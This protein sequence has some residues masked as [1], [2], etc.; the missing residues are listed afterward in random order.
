MLDV[1]S[2]KIKFLIIY[3]FISAFSIMAVYISFDYMKSSDISSVTN[4]YI[5]ASAKETASNFNK[6]LDIYFTLLD[7]ISQDSIFKDFISTKKHKMETE[8]H[9]LSTKKSNPYISEIKYVQNDGKEIIKIDEI[10]HPFENKI[11]S[12]IIGK[13]ELKTLDYK[14]EFN[15]LKKDE[16]GI[17]K[18]DLNLDNGKWTLL[19]EPTI[20]LGEL[21]YDN[22]GIEKGI[23]V[24]SIKFLSLFKDF[25]H[26][27]FYNIALVDSEGNFLIHDDPRYGLLSSNF[28]YS[29]K[30]EYPN[31]W[32][33]VLDED[34]YLGDSFYSYK[35]L[36]YG[37][38]EELNIILTNK[39]IDVTKQTKDFQKDFIVILVFLSL[40]LLPLVIYF[41]SLPDK[42]A[43]QMMRDFSKDSLTSLSNRFALMKDIQTDKFDGCLII[44]IS[45]D[46]LFKIQNTYGHT[47]SDK[48]VKQFV[49]SFSN[50]KGK[51]EFYSDS[52]NSY[53]LKYRYKGTDDLRTYV[54]KLMD[55]L[56]NRHFLLKEEN[57][58]FLL[59]ITIG[60]SNPANEY[61]NE[62]KLQEAEN[63]L[64]MAQDSHRKYDIYGVLHENNINFK[65][66]NISLAHNIKRY[67]DN[68]NVL[69][70]FQPI[71]NNM[72]ERI[73][74]YECL[75]RLKGDDGILFPDSFLPIAK[76]INQYYR[77]SYIMID[78]AFSFFQDKDYEFSI[79]LSVIDLYDLKFQEY[80]F[81]QIEKYGVAN[82]LVVEIVE[83]ESIN[84][85]DIF[86]DFAKRIKE[87]GAQIAIDDFGSGY[88]NFNY[89]IELSDYVDYLKIDGSLV[90]DIV[91]SHK[92]QILIGSLKFLSDNLNI[93]TIA[94]Y[95][96][97]E[98]VLRYLSSIGI[99]YSQ[100]YHIGKPLD[101][102]LDE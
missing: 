77:L 44:I 52:Y 54:N 41:A 17:S 31:E 29:L 71:Y 69:V 39:Y 27:E 46:N 73:E 26:T 72:T 57:I 43:K 70:Y 6:H 94:E 16:I 63:A 83:S 4:K 89:I 84:N 60:V 51:E 45:I 3:F 36:S 91:E 14:K 100:G 101:H 34:E 21:V 5:K 87:V 40:L 13:E 58:E 64:E 53:A 7:A 88:S 22:N 80:L 11:I 35:V 67:I 85:Y 56:E 30:D 49:N 10:D 90:K 20:K 96:E 38:D 37:L 25:I 92:I 42:L 93:K 81:N 19:N 99:D 55:D 18:I 76:E 75:I 78:K 79:N 9:F 97:D 33:H 12:R 68:D 59:Q 24:V 28:E 2:Y 1:Y 86:F 65:K 74:K 98:E 102:L 47:I 62:T 48:L 95:V 23:L 8:E 66:E 32:S 82:K 61:K 15:G 50:Y